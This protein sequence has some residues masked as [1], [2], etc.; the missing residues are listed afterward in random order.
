[1]S[2]AYEITLTI[3]ELVYSNPHGCQ[4]LLPLLAVNRAMCDVALTVLWRELPTAL[5]L[6]HLMPEDVIERHLA[7]DSVWRY[8]LHGPPSPS[9]LDRFHVYAPRVRAIISRERALTYDTIEAFAAIL[10]CHTSMTDAPFL[11]N[12]TC[13]RLAHGSDPVLEFVPSMINR[14]L[15]T[16]AIPQAVVE[17]EPILTRI[18]EVLPPIRNLICIEITNLT[19]LRDFTR[20]IHLLPT[21]RALTVT[22]LDPEGMEAIF[23]HPFLRNLTVIVDR[24]LYLPQH[25]PTFHHPLHSFSI[26]FRKSWL[27]GGMG[28]DDLDAALTLLRRVRP[29]CEQLSITLGLHVDGPALGKFISSLLPEPSRVALTEF[30]IFDLSHFTV[31]VE[32]ITNCHSAPFELKFLQPL[33]QVL[34]THID[35]SCFN[36]CLL[37]DDDLFDLSVSLPQIESLF[38]GCSRYFPTPPRASLVGVSHLILHCRALRELGL[39]FSCSLGTMDLDLLPRNKWI[40]TLTVGVSPPYNDVAVAAF[41]GRSLPSVNTIHVEDYDSLLRPANYILYDRLKRVE[42]WQNI[43]DRRSSLIYDFGL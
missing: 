12:L 34:L 5:P 21:L 27:G 9:Q 26:K 42:R 16:L 18:L 8:I 1:M 20:R 38:L 41:L 25:T 19:R 7:V 22:L 14:G 30:S 6:L 40:N 28:A 11:P 33:F 10:R 36:M 3:C 37:D 13:L 17:L 2:L 39:V 32:A 31:D 24:Q 23:S 29:P 35:L 15:E 4:H 43:L